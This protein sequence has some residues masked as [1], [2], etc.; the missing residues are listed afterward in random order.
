MDSNGE[1]QRAAQPEDLSRFFLEQANAG[2]I[3]GLVA[4]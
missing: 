4:L 2:D 1:R 3:D